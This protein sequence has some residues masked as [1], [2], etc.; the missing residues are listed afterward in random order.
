MQLEKLYGSKTKVDILKYLLF[1]RQGI[2]M[3]ALESELDWTFPAIKK[4]VDSL[5]ESGV[6]QIDKD[7]SGFS[8]SILPA[9]YELFKTFFFSALKADLVQLFES[10]AVMIDKY[11]RGKKFGVPLEMDLIIIYKYMEKPQID[12]LKQAIGEIFRDFFIEHVSIVFMSA[13][14]REKRYRLADRF[15]LQVMRF[16]SETK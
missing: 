15:V 4:Q 7:P 3:R 10:Y 5:E 6:L 9:H 11:F 1:R 16:F 14:E 2:S 13:E 8:I 12:A